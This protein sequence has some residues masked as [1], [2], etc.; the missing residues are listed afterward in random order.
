MWSWDGVESLD[1]S[2][3]AKIHGWGT[4][5]AENPTP[6]AETALPNVHLFHQ[7]IKKTI[8]SAV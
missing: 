1:C 6:D 2:L 4:Y 7:W 8:G 3:P 5:P